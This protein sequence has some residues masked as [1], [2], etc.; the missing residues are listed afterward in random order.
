MWESPADAQALSF[1]YLHL[2]RK[3]KLYGVLVACAVL[4]SGALAASA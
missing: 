4:C 2:M 3:M 1:C